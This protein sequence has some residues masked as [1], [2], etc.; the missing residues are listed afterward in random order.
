MPNMVKGRGNKRP[1]PK[2]VYLGLEVVLFQDRE[3]YK[4]LI[5]FRGFNFYFGK[6]WILKKNPK[7]N[8]NNSDVTPTIECPEILT[9]KATGKIVEPE[10]MNSGVRENDK[11]V[12]PEDM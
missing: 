10:D 6:V 5:N 2:G 8:T 11:V 4:F 1:L 12:E 9:P 7:R 3:G